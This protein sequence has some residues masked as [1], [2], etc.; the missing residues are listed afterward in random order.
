MTDDERPLYLRLAQPISEPRKLVGPVVAPGE[1]DAYAQSAL[2][3]ET[4]AV[5]S[6]VESTRNDTLNIAAFNL[7]QLVASGHLQHDTVWDALTD[8]A[9]T[10]GLTESETAKTIAS[11]FRAGSRLPREVPEKAPG[12]LLAVPEDRAGA[13]G[14]AGEPGDGGEEPWSLRDRLPRV[15]FRARWNKAPEDEE[16]VLY[17]I[18]PARR[19]VAL[20]SPPKLGKSLLMLEVAAAISMGRSALGH[21]IDQ[22]RRVLYVDFENDPDGDVIPR[23]KAMGFKDTD[24][25]GLDYL[26]FPPLHALDTRD[27]GMELHAATQE[28]ESEV[29]VI[30]TI[31]RAVAGEENDND[32]WL[33][34]YKNTGQVLKA[35]K[36]TTVR[37]DHTGKDLTKGMRGGSAKYGDVDVAWSMLPAGAG[38]TTFKLECVA[39]RLPI[40][41]RLV[42]IERSTNPLTHRVTSK[43]VG[44]V[45]YQDAL[46]YIK[47]WDDLDRPRGAYDKSNPHDPNHWSREN[48]KKDLEQAGLSVHEKTLRKAIEMRVQTPPPYDPNEGGWTDARPGSGDDL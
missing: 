35:S 18:I 3:G 6:A 11:G 41:D 22:P 30:D 8:A 12:A 38:E 17:P 24:L 10:A 34:F 13:S 33:N 44:D 21:A 45:L 36:I 29:V 5:A 4:G 31:S 19:I 9:L 26:S 16:W 1:A 2:A 25:D 47:V 42:L 28:Y 40:P 14:Q 32:T 48:Y 20:F 23:L 27:G 15:D 46:A 43:Q 39:N 7:S 37:L